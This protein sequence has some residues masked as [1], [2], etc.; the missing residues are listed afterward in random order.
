MKQQVELTQGHLRQKQNAAITQ[1]GDDQPKEFL[2][3]LDR[4][5]KKVVQHTKFLS[6]EMMSR[7]YR[8]DLVTSALTSLIRVI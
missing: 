7:H 1:L 6:V 4:T 2:H 5:Q 8:L 3:I